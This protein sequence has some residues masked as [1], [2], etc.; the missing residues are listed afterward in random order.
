MDQAELERLSDEALGRI[1][2]AEGADEL[3]ALEREYLG[4]GGTV[5]AELDLLSE[6]LGESVQVD[7]PY[8]ATVFIDDSLNEVDTMTGN[9]LYLADLQ[10][11]LNLVGFEHHPHGG[12]LYACSSGIAAI[13]PNGSP[14]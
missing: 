4:K 11:P 14:V 12:Q 6:E 5:H 3:R 1:R 10:T 8:D 7:V 9:Y 13:T 2:S